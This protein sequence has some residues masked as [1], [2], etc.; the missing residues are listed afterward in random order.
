MGANGKVLLTQNY[1]VE[2]NIPLSQL[3]FLSSRISLGKF[4]QEFCFDCAWSREFSS[5]IHFA[6][7]FR[8][9]GHWRGDIVKIENHK[10]RVKN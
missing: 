5:G 2:R 8:R 1:L 9:E 3:D 6:D 10:A 7:D 4:D